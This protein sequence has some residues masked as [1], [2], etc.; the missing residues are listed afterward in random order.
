LDPVAI[1]SASS[2]GRF[3]MPTLRY[4]TQPMNGSLFNPVTMPDVQLFG[5]A[6]P[7]DG[8]ELEGQLFIFALDNAGNS[9]LGHTTNPWSPTTM[10]WNVAKMGVDHQLKSRTLTV[11]NTLRKAGTPDE[12]FIFGTPGYLPGAL[13]PFDPN[14]YLAKVDL[15][16]PSNL[17][18]RAAWK[19]YSGVQGGVPVFVTGE[20]N[21]APL[22]S[23]PG[24]Q[25]VSVRYHAATQQ[26]IMLYMRNRSFG[27]QGE[28]SFVFRTAPDPTGPWSNPKSILDPTSEAYEV[29]MHASETFK[30]YDDGLYEK[31]DYFNP[32]GL[33][34]GEYAPYMTE[35]W[36][37][38]EPGGQAHHIIYSMSTTIPYQVHLV[39]TVFTQGGAVAPAQPSHP[40]T[41]LANPTFGNGLI[42]WDVE[43]DGLQPVVYNLNGLNRVSTY[44]A[45]GD[46]NKITI[47]QDF[48]VGTS[49]RFLQFSYCGGSDSNRLDHSST[50]N[51]RIKLMHGQE[52]VRSSVGRDTCGSHKAARWNLSNLVG[53][54]VT[55]VIE[56]SAPAGWW[57]FVDS[58]GFTQS[59]N[60]P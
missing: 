43:T 50:G 49:T 20:Q 36:F 3:N 44:N 19:Y 32:E 24:V 26:Y 16:D 9:V 18:M 60:P 47:K 39:D 28:E 21:A 33:W 22:L 52:M 2:V 55:L 35:N 10:S 34:G 12:L 29:F 30:G 6:T 8:L 13:Y 15:S 38:S 4:F 23:D 42:G 37:S 45:Q 57:G 54:T 11:V 46:Q 53:A 40:G 1:T 59:A 31:N 41:P 51:T 5:G 48:V 25:E 17:K 58:S 27:L 7:R 14:L 56:D